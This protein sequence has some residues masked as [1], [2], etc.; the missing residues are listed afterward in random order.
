VKLAKELKTNDEFAVKVLE[1]KKMTSEE[2][3]KK[4]FT[5]RNVFNTLSH[6][7]IVKLTYTFQDPK[8]LCNFTSQLR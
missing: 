4:V 1:K 3:K 6:P 2:S 5:E 7:N 8:Y